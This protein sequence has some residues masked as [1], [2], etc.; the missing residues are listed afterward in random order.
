MVIFVLILVIHLTKHKKPVIVNPASI[1]KMPETV[2]RSIPLNLAGQQ[3]NKILPIA[4]NIPPDIK[5]FHPGP[6]KVAPIHLPALRTN[7]TN[8]VQ[9]NPLRPVL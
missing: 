5:M 4:V 6:V 7:S 2:P 9:L 3:D 8:P 1:R